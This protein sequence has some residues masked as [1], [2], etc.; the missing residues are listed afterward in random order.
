[1]DANGCDG[2]KAR[3]VEN[4][5]YRTISGMRQGDYKLEVNN[6]RRRSNGTGFEVEIDVKGQLHNFTFDKALP[7]LSTV[8]VAL[9]RKTAAGIEVIPNLPPTQASK[10]LWGLTTQ[11]FVP[12]SLMLLSPNHWEDTGSG[13]GNK[14]YFFMLDGCRNDGSARGFFNEFLKEELNPHRKVIEMVGS[15]MKTDLSD[16]QLSGLGFSSTQR[17]SIICQVTGNFT[18]NITITF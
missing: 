10:V 12:V 17:N 14:H 16:R 13:V 3:P 4:I 18:R 7:T 11:T 15:K 2:M 5:F 9:L 8:T 1:M 6:Y